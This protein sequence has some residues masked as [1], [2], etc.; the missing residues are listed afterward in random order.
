VHGIYIFCA[1]YTDALFWTDGLKDEDSTTW[2]WETTGAEI[3]EF[4][5]GVNQPDYDN[6]FP[7]RMCFQFLIHPKNIGWY[8]DL[9]EFGSN[10]VICE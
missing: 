9:C 10:D 6:P 2:Y 3:A 7:G 5:W 1:E 4:F 8:D